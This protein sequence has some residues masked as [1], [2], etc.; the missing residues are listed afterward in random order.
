MN[1]EEGAALDYTFL[2]T[3]SYVSIEI[4]L[5]IVTAII[6]WKTNYDFGSE[7]EIRAFK[8]LCAS[9]CLYTVTECIYALM[10]PGYL[11]LTDTEIYISTSV[12]VLAVSLIEF[13][14]IWYAEYRMNSAFTDKPI[15]K[16]CT[17][18]LFMVISLC[19]VFSYQNESIL[20]VHDGQIIRGPFYFMVGALDI[21]FVMAPTLHAAYKLSHE[22]RKRL[23]QRYI[24]LISFIIFPAITAV[25][26]VA[27]PQTP[28]ISIGILS[29]IFF[30][31]IST[32]SAR[33]YNDMLTGIGNRRRLREDYDD[34]APSVSP[35]NPLIF[36]LVDIDRFKDINDTYGHLVG[37]KALIIVSEAL[38]RLQRHSKLKIARWGGDEF[39]VFAPKSTVKTIDNM[40]HM[41]GRS[42]KDVAEENK[43]AIPLHLSIGAFELTEPNIPL[44]EVLSRADAVMYEIKKR[45]H[46]A[47]DNGFFGDLI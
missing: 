5:F 33:I 40:N 27:V 23:R 18:V 34:H 3:F 35:S 41:I 47:L 8:Y 25:V 36:C 15:F 39:T 14:W 21:I 26:D 30:V 44:R 10:V 24:R 37:D 46:T 16:I 11:P 1:K 28:I 17:F 32:Q 45:H 31:F 7:N 13:A 6:M 42:I 4:T 22:R 12:G 38:Q 20:A 9:F 29:A 43:F 2:Y 19:L